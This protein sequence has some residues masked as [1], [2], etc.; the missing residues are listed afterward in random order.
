M[1]IMTA[2]TAQQYD[3]AVIGAGPGGYTAAI[4]ASLRGASTCLIE[5]GRLGGTCLNVGCIPTKA[6]LHA[7]SVN[8]EMSPDRLTRLGLC[9]TP[10]APDPAGVM[11]FVTE[12]VDKLRV[13]LAGLIKAKKVTVMEGRA[14]ITAPGSV[15]VVGADG[16]MAIKAGAIIVATGSTPARPASLNVPWDHPN[17]WTTD[18]A[19]I[20]GELPSSVLIIGG[21]VIGCELAAAYGGL[22]ADVTVVE[23]LERLCPEMPADASR[24]AARSL[25]ARGVDVR[26]AVR[27]ESVTVNDNGIEATLSD[28]STVRAARVLVAVGRVANTDGL[29]LDALGVGMTDGLVDVDD[30]CRTNVEGLYAVGDVAERRQYAHLAA[31]MGVVAAD[32]ATGHDSVDDRSVVPTGMYTE[33]EVASVGMSLEQAVEAGID[34]KAHRFMLAANAMDLVHGPSGGMVKLTVAQGGDDAG[35]ILGALIIAPRAT[36]LVQVPA[37]AMKCGL[38]VEDLAETIHSHPTFVES[39]QGAA[40]SAMGLPLHSLR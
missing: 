1:K 33:P 23:M 37:L 5:A 2:D 32:N 35:R 18:E 14:T 17:V 20:A 38:R 39:L 8:H 25:K 15:S 40:E 28:Q 34:A 31:R 10:D 22:G 9:A 19:C 29:A 30:R 21:G 7:A 36:E 13:G 12:T 11:R 26:A 6:L 3:V 16:E 4:R 27:V 24:S